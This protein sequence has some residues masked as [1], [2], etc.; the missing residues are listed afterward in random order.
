MIYHKLNQGGMSPLHV[1]PLLEP[2]Q[3]AKQQEE[4]A[5]ERRLTE[6]RRNFVRNLKNRFPGLPY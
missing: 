6:I 4:Q 2:K 5:Q 3:T 1:S